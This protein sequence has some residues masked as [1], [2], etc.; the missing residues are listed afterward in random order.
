[1]TYPPKQAKA[2]R[3]DKRRRKSDFVFSKDTEFDIEN[4]VSQLTRVL[5]E[6]A[7]DVKSN[8]ITTVSQPFSPP[9]VEEIGPF[10][11]S[12]RDITMATRQ[13]SDPM[14]LDSVRWEKTMRVSAMNKRSSPDAKRNDTP[15][16]GREDSSSGQDS[17]TPKS[18]KARVELCTPS[19]KASATTRSTSK[20]TPTTK[21][22]DS[23]KAKRKDSKADRAQLQSPPTKSS[24][25]RQSIPTSWE[26]ASAS[27]ILMFELRKQGAEFPTIAKVLRT[28][29]GLYYLSRTLRNRYWKI[30]TRIGDMPNNL[31]A[32]KMR[33]YS[34][35]CFLRKDNVGISFANFCL[36]FKLEKKDGVAEEMDEETSGL[37]SPTL[38]EEEDT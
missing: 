14:N 37:S 15:S 13:R 33:V 10:H 36:F 38:D 34:C 7:E 28:T 25:T 32:S 3:E 29:C 35:L 27:D 12:L 18:K 26:E 23:S 17:P 22:T 31:Q 11:Y 5:K 16:L 19:K 1:M 24:R 30:K 20:K 6:I 8:P 4:S 9:S 21:P 2:H